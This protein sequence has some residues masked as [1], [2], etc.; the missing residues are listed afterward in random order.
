[1]HAVTQGNVLDVQLRGVRAPEFTSAAMG[2]GAPVVRAAML[3]ATRKAAD[4]MMSR[5]PA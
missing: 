1:M 5:F 2:S 4:V 3:S